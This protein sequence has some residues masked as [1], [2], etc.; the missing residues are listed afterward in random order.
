MD[1]LPPTAD[2]SGADQRSASVHAAGQRAAPSLSRDLRESAAEV[3]GLGEIADIQKLSND[4]LRDALGRTND[5]QLRLDRYKSTIAAE[6]AERSR[7]DLGYAGLAQSKGF[8]TPEAFIQSV[9][10]STRT[11]ATTLVRVGSMMR[12]IAAAEELAESDPQAS[13]L[14]PCEISWQSPLAHAVNAGAISVDAAEAI[15]RGIGTPDAAITAD[16]LRRGCDALVAAAR[17]DET[18]GVRP[19]V[20]ELFRAARAH[21]D[22]IDSEAVARRE[23]AQGDDQYVRVH[24]RGDGMVEG[25]FRLAPENGDFLIEFL[26]QAT[27]P[28]RG[29]PRF[30][31]SDARDWAQRAMEDPRTNEQINVDTLIGA[32]RVAASADHSRLP[33][34]RPAVRVITTAET[35]TG[36]LEASRTSISVETVERHICD[37]GT[38]DIQMDSRGQVL[39][40]GV[41]QRLFTTAQRIALAVRWGGCAFSE[42]CD[43]PPSWC[44]AHHVL[45]FARDG[46][47]TDI[48]NGILLCRH[49]HMLVHNN[50]WDITLDDGDYR[51]RPPSSVDPHRTPRL[52]R[53]KNDLVENLR[54]ENRSVENRPDPPPD[55]LPVHRQT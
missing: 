47:K 28:R 20:D 37:G 45:W 15:R 36:R 50:G 13:E 21:R 30:V 22:L 2:E 26:D 11:E 33:G 6:I 49:H 9:T 4:E 29:G 34:A 40:L 43:R 31:D 5:H 25:S 55:G 44:E 27:S 17:G 16:D 14:F 18:A 42:S 48:A 35:S 51:I 46:G 52:L 23:K 53:S 3:A 41:E 10:G 7:H 39:N 19:T 24:R 12:E 1:F 32:L 38:I 8:R 54:L